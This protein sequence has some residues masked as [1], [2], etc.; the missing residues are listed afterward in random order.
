[1]GTVRSK[2][3]TTLLPGLLVVASCTNNQPVQA[4]N[5]PPVITLASPDALPDNEPLPIEVGEGL[6]FEAIV[7]DAED[8]NEEL[9]VH[10]IAERTDQGGVQSDLGDT[11]PDSS[12]RTTKVV[13]GLEAGT[14]QIVA[15]VEDTRGAT[16]EVG[17]PV[18]IFAVNEAPTALI[19]QP[20]V[21]D[22]FI[23]EDSIT[24]VG[25]ATDDRDVTGLTV[26]WFS[27]RD[28]L[29]NSSAPISSGLMTFSLDTLSP[30][31]HTVTVLITDEEGLTGEDAVVFDVI[32][33]D[34]PPNAPTI[35]ITP[36]SPLSTEDL[37]CLI[38]VGSADPDGLPITYSYTWFRNGVQSLIASAVLPASETAAGDE[39]TCQ[40]IANDGT[41]DSD[42]GED[43]VTIENQ[44]PTV[45]DAIL[46]PAPAFETSTLTCSGLNWQDADG[47]PEGYQYTW[48]VEGSVVSGVTTATL[49]G[50]WFDRDQTVQCELTPDDGNG[51]GTP[52]L[53]N[54]ITI[55]NSAPTPPTVS[56]S[57][58]TQ[59]D[60]DDDITCTVDV[61]SVD[62]DG[63]SFVYVV[64]W[65]LD[66][67]YDPAYDGQWTIPSA[68]TGLGDVWECSVSGDDLEDLGL[69]GVDSTTVL[70]DP[71][72]FV[73][74]EFMATPAAVSD[75][76]GEWVELYNN[77]G[78][79]M[80]LN[81]FTLH[82]DGTDTHTINADIVLPPGARAVLIR[83]LDFATNGGVF[84]A[85][86]YSGF[87]L[88]DTQDQI[89]LSFQGAEIDRFNYDLT[90]YS[91]PLVGRALALD[92]DLGDPD[93]TLNDTGSNWCGSSNPLVLPGSDFGT[94]GGVNDACACYFSDGDNDGYGTDPSC[95][96]ADCDDS[97]PGFSPAAFDICE[98]NID[99]NCDGA[100]AICPCIDTDS[101]G[102]GFGDGL[103]CNPVDCDDANT[104]I[105]PG[106]P[107]ICDGIDDNCSGVPDDG[108]PALM[109]PPT[110]GGVVTTAC[111]AATCIITQC[112]ANQYDV[113]GDYSNGCEVTDVVV[114]TCE[115]QS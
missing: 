92:P 18:A 73:I 83:N 60:T 29:I 97:D 38:T 48:V 86:E 46:G 63:D 109:C 52:V 35:E 79:T 104:L 71:G 112:A 75:A 22:D 65:S 6:T 102:D 107:E 100:D 62:P 16:D 99:Q 64:T 88:G 47:D 89:V 87:T 90:T 21:G 2:R 23:E 44:L 77:S 78:S 66:G 53:S 3:L 84:A 80:N 30:G 105:Y 69:P 95:A 13:G 40:V 98:D 43:T 57:P 32:P 39:W 20:Q 58:A 7:S 54:I 82:D 5:Q 96:W 56:I 9:V 91:P 85:Y 72:D 67:V 15:R 115:R 8:L 110:T 41:L 11:Q 31:E 113:D 1:M 17:L 106:A 36:A 10:W 14:Y 94:P 33:K 51:L 55:V 12:G 19:T 103:A 42:P 37:N 45:D 108:D 111:S 70:P 26:E 25:T 24:F 50:T 101:D 4:V 59:A 61:D 76:A 49:D 34:L 93:W 27:S 68:Q 74:S 114:N 81:G 28:G